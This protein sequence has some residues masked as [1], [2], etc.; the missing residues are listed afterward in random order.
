MPVFA[1]IQSAKQR[2]AG[3]AHV[4]P[5]MTSRTLNE[6]VG[7]NVYL[8]CENFQKIGAFKYRGAFNAIAQ[9]SDEQRKRGVI[10]FSSGNHGQA[11]A[12]VGRTL[13]IK[14]V[15]VMPQ[16]ATATKRM[17]TA[18]YGAEIITCDASERESIARTYQNEH[19]LTLVPPFDD[20]NVIAG[21][22]T[23]ALE[24]IEQ[25][26]P[27]DA[28]LIPTG[29]GGLLSGCA[30]A[31]KGACG[32]CRVIGIEPE[33]GDDATRSFR[34]KSLQVVENCKSIADGTRTRSLGQKTFPLILQHV[35]EMA[36]VS[37]GAIMDAV[38]FLFFRMKLVVEPSGALGIAALLSGAVQSRGRIG[39]IISGGNIDAPTMTQIFSA[40]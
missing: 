20:E 37:E 21:Q 36:T 17:A 6:R 23:T 27:L 34:S 15:V 38:R 30:I 10:T 29:G 11:V 32:A 4:T 26:G 24:F 33:T 39:V 25:V 3:N 8:K 18:G 1:D 13:R 22:G 12:F 40:D 9:L 7:A 16:D 28:L 5:V 35:D 19:G 14:T 31:A 2:L